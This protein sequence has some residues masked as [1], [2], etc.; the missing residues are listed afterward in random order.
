M[1]RKPHITRELARAII[2]YD[3]ATG[4]FRWRHRPDQSKAWNTKYAGKIAGYSSVRGRQTYWALSMQNYP[5]LAHRLAFIYMTG[6]APD[7]IDHIDGDGL[8]NA[9]ANLRPADKI[10]NGANSRR[11]ITNTSGYKGVCFS[12][13]Q[14]KWR[15]SI[16]HNRKHIALGYFDTPEEAHAAYARKAAELFGE[17]ARAA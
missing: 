16:N 14:Q 6:V 13:A 12:K 9:W 17:F 15:A 4:V 1:S 3:A 8:N 10:T 2:E 11:R 5:I 7:L